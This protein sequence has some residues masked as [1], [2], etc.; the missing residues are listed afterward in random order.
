MSPQ[1][2]NI[3]SMHICPAVYM[4]DIWGDSVLHLSQPHGSH[5]GENVILASNDV[6]TAGRDTRL[7]AKETNLQLEIWNYDLLSVDAD[8]S[9][10]AP[11]WLTLGPMKRHDKPQQCGSGRRVTSSQCDVI[12]V[13]R[14]RD[15]STGWRRRTSNHV[16]N[17]TKKWN[18]LPNEYEVTQG[19]SL[20]I[21]KTTCHG[22]YQ[23]S[24]SKV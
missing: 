10:M 9:Q 19:L 4:G 12:I 17:Q 8:L 3:Q 23:L 11:F 15:V 1:C 6:R 7:A 24:L 21:H 18:K 20:S 13:W 16:N 22:C 5:T 14:H 2:G